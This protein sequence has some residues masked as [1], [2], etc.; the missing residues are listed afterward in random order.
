MLTPLELAIHQTGADHKGGIKDLSQKMAVS[1]STL[2]N[3]LNPACE[4]HRLSIHEALS[5]ML[6]TRNFSILHVIAD[7]CGFVLTPKGEPNNSGDQALLE[8]Y[9]KVHAENG[10]I[11]RALLGALE[12]GKFTPNEINE[13]TR[14]VHE[15]VEALQAFLRRVRGLCPTSAE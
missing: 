3:K 9:G 5:L 2:A 6:I 4:G 8:A 15:N 10:D 13:I 1:Y 7:E 11:A 12:D 14:E